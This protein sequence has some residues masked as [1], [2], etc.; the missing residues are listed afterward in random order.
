MSQKFP[1]C[2]CTGS[3]QCGS[4]LHMV[5]SILLYHNMEWLPWNAQLPV[6]RLVGHNIRK[7]GRPSQRTLPSNNS[8]KSS[9]KNSFRGGRLGL[10]RVFSNCWILEDT[11]LFTGTPVKGRTERDW[12]CGLAHPQEHALGVSAAD[13]KSSRVLADQSL[14][15]VLTHLTSI[16]WLPLRKQDL[17]GASSLQS[18]PEILG[19]GR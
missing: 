7:H 8:S 18:N 6:S 16:H 3:S 10:F 19:G 11:L 13:L 9:T 12:S 17:F 14:R 1:T 4:T 2:L 5:T 15:T